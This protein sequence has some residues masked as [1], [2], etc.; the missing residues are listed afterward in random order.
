MTKR[1][2]YLS[3]VAAYLLP[4][5]SA[6]FVVL[7]WILARRLPRYLPAPVVPYLDVPMVAAPF[8]WLLMTIGC[9]VWVSYLPNPDRAASREK[10]PQTFG[11]PAG[12][13]LFFGQF[14]LG[15][16]IIVFGLGALLW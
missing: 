9:A 3:V 5:L 10:G 4:P 14:L 7:A 2:I 12:C 13:G 16:M 8:G 11:A 6:I 15:V 1:R